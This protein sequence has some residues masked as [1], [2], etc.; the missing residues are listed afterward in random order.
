[1]DTTTAN[2]HFGLDDKVEVPESQ[3]ALLPKG[4][5]FFT[6]TKRIISREPYG[7]YGVTTLVKLKIMV[8]P[9]TGNQTGMI[10]YTL[11]LV[12]PLGWKIINVATA[13]GLRKHGDGNEIDP[14]WWSQLEGKDGR[15]V[16]GHRLAKAKKEGQTDRTFNEIEKFLAPEEGEGLNLK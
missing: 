12:R 3:Y 5:A 8:T 11:A 16:I 6:I 13:C 7:Q 1:M 4:E 15:C 10:D 9:V 14:R 2:E